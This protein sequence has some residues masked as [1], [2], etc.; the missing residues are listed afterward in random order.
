MKKTID[1]EFSRFIRLAT[2]EEKERVYMEVMEKA[3]ERQLELHHRYYSPNHK[4]E[5]AD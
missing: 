5:T 1:S 3:T 4:A 2:P